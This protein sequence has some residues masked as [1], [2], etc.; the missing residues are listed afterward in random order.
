MH[1]NKKIILFIFMIFIS[2]GKVNSS[3]TDSLFM[4]VGNKPITQSDIINEIKILLILSN[5]SYTEDKRDQLQK[6]AM[7]SLIKR[8]IMRIEI[9]KFNITEF[10]I[11]DLENELKRFASKMNV[12]VDTL[13][14]ICESNEINF[15]LIEDLITV[16]LLWNILVFNLYKNRLIVNSA[17]IDEELKKLEK[18]KKNEY[19]IS[20]IL[21]PISDADNTANTII[22]LKKKIE[23]EG[24]ENVAENLSI[25]ESSLKGGDLG[26]LDESIISEKI[27]PAIVNTPIGK[28]SEAIIL[29]EGILLFK[30]RDKKEIKSDLTL[31][32]KK[33]KLVAAEKNK[34]LGMYSLTHYDKVKRSIAIK[35]LNE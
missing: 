29:P 7:Q 18:I 14:N 22:D 15:S 33:N 16:E 23:I 5:E 17:D 30:V 21:I 3:I 35:F 25:S 11:T 1:N 31:E 2:I 26:W 4:S 24:F 12:D 9:E 20:E 34:I 10:N 32:D 13:K 27:K 6:Q 28:I 19:L 8:N